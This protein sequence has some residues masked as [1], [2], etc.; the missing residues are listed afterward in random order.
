MAQQPLIELGGA[1]NAPTLHLA[2]ANGFVA[3]TYLPLLRYLTDTYH[4]VCLPPRA[5]WGDLEP[6]DLT[7]ETHDWRQLADD[8]LAGFD[9]YALNDLVAIGH[10][11]G[12]IA[13][14][15]AAIRQPERFKAMIFL[16]PTLLDPEILGWMR[17]AQAAGQAD[18]QPLA[19]IALRRSRDF[20]SV[21]AV[22]ERFRSKKVFAQWPDETVRLYAEYGTVPHQDKRRLAWSPEWEAFYYSTGYTEMWDDVPKLSSLDVPMLFLNGGDSDTFIESSVERAQ[23]LV[24]QATFRTIEGHGHL[25][26]QSAPAETAQMIHEWLTTI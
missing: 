24:P 26:P 9:Q 20:D 4:A 14:M 5:L 13:T 11:F 18:E 12:G 16:D 25:F 22:Y 17:Q 10:S 23:R 7:P 8:L 3:Q 2:L 19:Q 15:L 21:E 6:P 1:P